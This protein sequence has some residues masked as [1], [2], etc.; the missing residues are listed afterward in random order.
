[1]TFNEYVAEVTRQ[2]TENRN[3]RLGQTYFNVLYEFR[4][5]LSEQIRA[6]KLDPF[7][8]TESSELLVVLAWIKSHW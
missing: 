5:D 2:H 1:M 4:P 6:T 3:W 8:L 7:Y